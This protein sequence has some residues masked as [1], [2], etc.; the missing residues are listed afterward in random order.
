M[1]LESN[2]AEKKKKTAHECSFSLVENEA[3]L[4][5]NQDFLIEKDI[6]FSMH[7]LRKCNTN[8]SRKQSR[9]LAD[10]I[11]REV[12]LQI[13]SKSGILYKV[14]NAERITNY[15]QRY[16]QFSEVNFHC[17][18]MSTCTRCFHKL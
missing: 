14:L 16:I 11:K 3:S 13:W 5:N 6:P 10:C 1:W 4:I 8:N 17:K 12:M 18:I 7:K 15:P 9:F 2:M